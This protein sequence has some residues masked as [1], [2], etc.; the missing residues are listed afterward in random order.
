MGMS[1]QKM[2]QY[3]KLNIMQIEVKQYEDGSKLHISKHHDMY[4]A[5]ISKSKNNSVEIEY[6]WKYEAE[7]LQSVMVWVNKVKKEPLR[8]K[9]FE[10]GTYWLPH[11]NGFGNPDGKRRTVVS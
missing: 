4:V 2:V 3:F 9:Y 11:N 7:S 5:K 8:H 10:S 6:I 1:F